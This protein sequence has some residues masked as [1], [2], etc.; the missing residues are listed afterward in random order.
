MERGGLHLGVRASAQR[1]D[2]AVV[3]AVAEHLAQF[4]AALPLVQRNVQEHDL[5]R[6]YR[7]SLQELSAGGEPHDEV[8]VAVE[9][10]HCALHG[11]LVVI[12]DEHAHD[13]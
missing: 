8:P 1:D 13:F 6:I 11:Q 3:A 4:Y 2:L 10:A 7:V 5:I 9:Q 12:H